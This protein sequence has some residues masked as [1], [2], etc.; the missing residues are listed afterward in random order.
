MG[1]SLTL[2]VDKGQSL[3]AQ[4]TALLTDQDAV[5]LDADKTQSGVA[6][7]VKSA[8]GIWL[9]TTFAENE[10]R[11]LYFPTKPERITV[12]GLS[13]SQTPVSTLTTYQYNNGKFIATQA[14]ASEGACLVS[15]PNDWANKTVTIR[16]A[17]SGQNETLAEGFV[18][19]VRQRWQT[20]QTSAAIS[21]T[22]QKTSS[23]FSPQRVKQW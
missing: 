16:F 4:Q 1:R 13:V 11:P 5:N 10:T 19:M 21:T 18:G 17:A 23:T 15:V 9:T 12:D 8:Q 22:K 14:D 6:E 20:F 7:G 3:S 2:S